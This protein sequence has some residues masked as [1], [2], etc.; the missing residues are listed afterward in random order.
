MFVQEMH[1]PIDFCSKFI[2][3]SIHKAVIVKRY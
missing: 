2:V 3:N 1:Y